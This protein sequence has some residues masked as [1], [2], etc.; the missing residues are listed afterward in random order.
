[1]QTRELPL[2]VPPWT[3]F[4]ALARMP[5]SFFF[6]AGQEWGNERVSCMGFRPRMQFR[7][8]ASEASATTTL[9]R[10]DAVLRDLAPRASDH[11]APGRVPFAGGIVLA[12]SYECKNVIERLPQTQ[13]EDPDAPRLVGAVYDAV[14]AYEHR[15]KRWLVAS[16]HLDARALAHYADEVLE[17]LDQAGA[18]LEGEA[19]PAHDET[20]APIAVGLDPSEH[21]ARVARIQQY[22]AAGDVYQVNLTQ[23]CRVPLQ[24]APLG[25]YGRLRALQPAP[26][27]GYF[28]LGREQVLSNSPELFL[29]RRGDSVMTCPI[30]GTRRRGTTASEDMALVGQLCNDPKERAE[31]LMIVDLERNDLGRVCRVGTVRVPRFQEVLTLATVHHLVSTVA[32]ELMSGTSTGDLL[33]ATFPSGSVTGAPKIR[34]L[35]IIDEVERGPRGFYTGTL[36]WIDASGDCDLNVAIRTAIAADGML[37]YHVGGGIVADS[38]AEREYAECWLK[39]RA[40]RQA[41]RAEPAAAGGVGAHAE[42]H[43]P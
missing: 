43:V 38:D 42:D 8:T 13:P 14:V 12:L 3:F 1:M 27:G 2:D 34:A 41:L 36:G 32:G 30:K 31:H 7:V 26:F 25:L 28:D 23:R 11:T 24:G 15:R 16:W 39:A 6:D 17:A 21:A 5:R 29:R 9:D 33:R 20:P 22:I 37:T 19:L 35:E 40:L 18:A 4:R 10:L